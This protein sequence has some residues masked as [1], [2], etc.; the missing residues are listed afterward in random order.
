MSRELLS[1]R[2]LQF[3]LL[4]INFEFLRNKRILVT[5]GSGMIG[6]FLIESLLLGTQESGITIKELVTTSKNGNFNS[7]HHLCKDFNLEL[8]L[9]E[10]M[11]EKD[12]HGFDFVIHSGGPS[13]IAKIFDVKDAENANST[14][15]NYILN[16]SPESV[17]YLSSS[18]V[19]NFKPTDESA[20]NLYT[21]TKINAEK[22]ISNYKLDPNTRVNAVRLFHTFGPGVRKNDGRSFADF[23]WAVAEGRQ[24]ILN[25]SGSQ[26]RTFLYSID[27][28]IAFLI[29]ISNKES[30]L[31]IDV[32]S[33]NPIKIVDFARKVSEIGNLFGLLEFANSAKNYIASPYD[34]LVPDCTKIRE[35]G[36]SESTTIDI[37]ISQTLI[38]IKNQMVKGV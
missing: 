16:G 10:F 37:G 27:A 13:S 12:Y 29:I 35:L 14:V 7:I 22:L 1:L 21:H 20:R 38:W 28:I 36:W 11:K 4:K 32:G 33:E 19:S 2:D 24:P 9:A 18:Q 26:I 23:L 31:I 30:G 3:L 17:C 15:L 8:K 6:S 34:S 5:G 25:T